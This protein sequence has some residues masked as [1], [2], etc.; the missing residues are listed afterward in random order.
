MIRI[1]RHPSGPRVYIG[2]R[3]LHH[4][5]TGCIGLALALAFGPRAHRELW[6]LGVATS[7]AMAFHD[8]A[9]FP[10]RDIDNHE[11]NR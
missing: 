4:G 3:R 6:L 11:R 10:F 5:A 9:D 1:T 2:G 7:G 8:R